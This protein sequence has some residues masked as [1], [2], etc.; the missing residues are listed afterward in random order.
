[1]QHWLRS[2]PLCVTRDDVDLP[3]QGPTKPEASFPQHGNK[4]TKR[5]LLENGQGDNVEQC[6]SAQWRHDAATTPESRPRILD[7]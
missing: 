3:A 6:M 7:M 5:Y 2:I 4:N 1:M